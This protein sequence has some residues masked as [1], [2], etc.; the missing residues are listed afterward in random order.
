MIMGGSHLSTEESESLV[1]L[2]FFFFF[3]C[4][5]AGPTH[6]EDKRNLTS[7]TTLFTSGDCGVA[8]TGA[9]RDCVAN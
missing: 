6:R 7:T 4:L 2:R 3:L 5:A 9:L 1:S 8:L